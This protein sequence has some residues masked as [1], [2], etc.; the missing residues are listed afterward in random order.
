LVVKPHRTCYLIAVST[1][2]DSCLCAVGDTHGHLQLALGMAARWQEELGLGFDAVLL[3]GD[4]GTFT[5]PGQLDNATRRHARNNPC[6][7]EF[8]D[9]WAAVPQPEWIQKLFRRVASASVRSAENAVPRQDH[10]G[11]GPPALGTPGCRWARP[12]VA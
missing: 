5:E 10:D 2:P 3:C 4:V 6:E 12:A 8:L 9:Q 7:L 11:C 1:D